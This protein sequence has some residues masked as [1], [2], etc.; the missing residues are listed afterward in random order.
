M[1]V[2]NGVSLC[3]SGDP[4]GRCGHKPCGCVEH[5][6]VKVKTEKM[7]GPQYFVKKR[8]EATYETLP[9]CNCNID[10]GITEY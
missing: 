5:V 3:I 4:L 2:S 7:Y 1:L 6:I 9:N 10:A 8:K